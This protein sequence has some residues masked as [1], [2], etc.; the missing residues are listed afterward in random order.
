M[1]SPP[2]HLAKKIRPDGAVSPL[3][4]MTPRVLNL[5]VS[6]WTLRNEAVTCRKCLTLIAEAKRFMSIP[7]PP[8]WLLCLPP[9]G[10]MSDQ[11]KPG[12]ELD[13]RIAERLFGWT[14]LDPTA[15]WGKYDCGDPGCEWTCVDEPWCRGLGISPNARHGMPKPYP[16]FSEDIAAAWHIVE[17]LGLS[18]GPTA[19]DA[20]YRDGWFAEKPE[21]V[22][23]FAKAQTAPHAICLAALK[24]INAV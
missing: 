7:L 5:K 11:L 6:T 3:C 8:S 16:R 1:N 13:A 20:G 4:A 9:S 17:K 23:S 12:R 21:R 19:D 2:V 22:I 18:V 24:A 10:P 15:R 14:G